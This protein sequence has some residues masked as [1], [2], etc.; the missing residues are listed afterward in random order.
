[1]IGILAVDRAAVVNLARFLQRILDEKR[2]LEQD[3]AARAAP[4][5]FAVAAAEQHL[6]FFLIN[7]GADETTD[8]ARRLLRAKLDSG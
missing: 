7:V 6:I 4:R 3:L 8:L 1:M 5:T 2:A